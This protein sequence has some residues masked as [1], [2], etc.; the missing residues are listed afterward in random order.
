ML[1]PPATYPLPPKPQTGPPQ[2]GAGPQH[3]ARSTPPPA[4]AAFNTNA[5]LRSSYLSS[6]Q[7]ASPKTGTGAGPSNFAKPQPQPPLSVGLP[8]YDEPHRTLRKSLNDAQVCSNIHLLDLGQG[9]KV[10]WRAWRGPALLTTQPAAGPA[11]SKNDSAAPK[12]T[13][14]PSRPASPSLSSSAQGESA[15]SKRPRPTPLDEVMLD[16]D[17]PTA[18]TSAHPAPQSPPL[19]Q[20]LQALQQISLASDPVELARQE[21]LRIAANCPTPLSLFSFVKVAPLK[22]NTT[23][24]EKGNKGKEKEH[25]EECEGA[26][27]ILWV[28]SLRRGATAEPDN[29][30]RSALASLEFKD[31]T[32]KLTRSRQCFLSY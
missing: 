23:E 2:L 25:T 5:G 17:G 18:S 21:V 6:S 27:R 7:P 1:P 10:H 12:A 9:W 11:S 24:H 14:V 13:A 28:F 22:S 31:L 32:S 20:K 3:A 8:T 16:V 30:S 26:R 15:A 19:K 29:F 4:Q